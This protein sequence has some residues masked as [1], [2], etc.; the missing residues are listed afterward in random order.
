LTDQGSPRRQVVPR[1]L[2]LCIL[3]FAF[4]L[5]VYRLDTQSLR[6]DEAATVH[7]SAMP[8][9]ELWELSRITDPHP[10]GFYLL[11][12]PWQWLLGKNAWLLRYPGVIASLLSIAVLYSLARTTLRNISAALLAAAL[13]A[14][15]PF[16]IWLAQ[17]LRSYS[18]FMLL[19][20]LS[21]WVLWLAL[22]SHAPRSKKNHPVMRWLLYIIL[23]TG[24]LYVHY[25]A[26]FLM[27]FQGLF[28][29][30]NAKK[31]WAKKWTWLASQTAI[32]LLI[33]PGLYLA[34]HLAGQAA[35][36]IDTIPTAEI[37]RRAATA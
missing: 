14:L 10:P 15:N 36:G 4:G 27:A 1:L 37:F 22:N 7:Y 35:G 6:G 16:Q 20:L 28:A 18:V 12:H 17:D 23:T 11:L 13:L 3:L 19:G 5:R 32:G 24:C 9:S 34:S 31:F 29:L 2:I 8:V 33:L 26:V 30:L 21:S 25:Y